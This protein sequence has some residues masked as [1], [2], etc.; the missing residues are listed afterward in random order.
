MALRQGNRLGAQDRFSLFLVIP[1]GRKF[2]ALQIPYVAYGPQAS[3][4]YV[5]AMEGMCACVKP[6]VSSTDPASRQ[7]DKYLVVI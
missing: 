7:I 1:F 4:V 6:M 2:K 5:S 3:S